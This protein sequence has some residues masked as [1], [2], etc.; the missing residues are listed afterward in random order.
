[1]NKQEIFERYENG[2]E[3]EKNEYINIVYPAIKEKAKNVVYSIQGSLAIAHLLIDVGDFYNSQLINGLKP[4]QMVSI[5][6]DFEIW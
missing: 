2:E 5:E 3:L 1:M 4:N 6:D